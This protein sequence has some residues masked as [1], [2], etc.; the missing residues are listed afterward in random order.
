MFLFIEEKTLN[1]KYCLNLIVVCTI[2]TLLLMLCRHTHQPANT[3]TKHLSY[4]LRSTDQGLNHTDFMFT[5]THCGMVLHGLLKS[6]V[7]YKCG[8]TVRQ[9]CI[10]TLCIISVN[11]SIVKMLMTFEIFRTFYKK[12]KV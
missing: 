1:T 3:T 11:V 5:H 4:V 2:S 8:H 12:V 9:S 7:D 10:S 6:A